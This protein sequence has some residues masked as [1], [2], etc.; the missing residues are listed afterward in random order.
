MSYSLGS[1]HLSPLSTLGSYS[2]FLFLLIPSLF[3]HP[4][5]RSSYKL[6]HRLRR[7][8]R[9]TLAAAAVALVTSAVNMVVL[10]VMHGQQ[11][12]WLCLG[13]CGTDVTINALALYF[14]T[15]PVD[16]S[17]SIAPFDHAASPPSKRQSANGGLRKPTTPKTPQPLEDA[18]QL[19][20]SYASNKGNL[21]NYIHPTV[22]SQPQRTVHFPGTPRTDG[23]DISEYE[24]SDKIDV[25]NPA[26]LTPGFLM[27]HSGLGEKRRG[28]D[29]KHQGRDTDAY[30]VVNGM[31]PDTGTS[32]ISTFQPFKADRPRA[33]K[34]PRRNSDK[35]FLDIAA[36]V[37]D[38]ET[39]RC[40]T[41]EGES[42]EV[43]VRTEGP[44][45]RPKVRSQS[46]SG[47]PASSSSRRL[48][49]SHGNREGQGDGAGAF[50]SKVAA[51]FRSNDTAP[52]PSTSMVVN[53]KTLT[54]EH[55][56]AT[57]P[58]QSRW[59][60]LKKAQAAQAAQAFVET[61]V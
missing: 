8:A 10:T 23:S 11:L 25:T 43:Q 13:S 48:G 60:T 55:T 42:T 27:N 50:V 19:T 52:P 14:V 57:D 35:R 28:E 40:S 7:L 4:L 33:R 34:R 22:V 56:D 36:A 51:I 18:P 6:T 45:P 47:R 5:Y 9:R 1:S 29:S 24:M 15:G 31:A 2:Y 53:V 37:H 17:A 21:T 41:P 61:G 39:P 26:Q 59:N 46:R 54:E 12:G 44:P 30:L 32:N 58:D 38:S 3:L 20:V 16:E 49:S